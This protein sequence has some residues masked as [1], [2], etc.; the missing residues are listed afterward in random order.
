MHLQSS[1]ISARPPPFYE[2][3]SKARKRVRGGTQAQM[4]LDTAILLSLVAGI[5][6][7]GSL[8]IPQTRNAIDRFAPQW[9]GGYPVSR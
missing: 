1:I 7:H 8:V 9:K 4:T 3:L 6:A 5:S 2:F